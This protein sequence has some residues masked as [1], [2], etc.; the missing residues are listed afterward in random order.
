MTTNLFLPRIPKPSS[1]PNAP[2]K[3]EIFS[4]LTTTFM[5]SI[6][7]DIRKSF[8]GLPTQLQSKKR[9][10]T[11]TA[12]GA[13]EN[14]DAWRVDRYA[15]EKYR[16]MIV[17]V[18]SLGK[19]EVDCSVSSD[20]ESYIVNGSPPMKNSKIENET[21]L[22][23]SFI[24]TTQKNKNHD[25]FI[26]PSTT[27][28]DTSI[29]S[30]SDERKRKRRRTGEELEALKRKKRGEDGGGMCTRKTCYNDLCKM[31]KTLCASCLASKRNYAR[32]SKLKK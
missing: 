19:D 26:N 27:N 5:R 16:V 11:C 12:K 14:W 4:C 1:L 31:S 17:G 10:F 15:I 2:T 30:N 8:F 23:P 7:T 28:D 20:E 9:K 18:P 29:N 22:L 24:S 25:A 32:H 6:W 3:E 21:E 13:K